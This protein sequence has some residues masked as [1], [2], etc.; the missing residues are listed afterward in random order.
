M[1]GRGYGGSAA[2]ED[3]VMRNLLIAA[4]VALVAYQSYCLVKIENERQALLTGMCKGPYL[5]DL[6][7]L[8]SVQTRT[9]WAWHLVVALADP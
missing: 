1:I 6:E 4:L 7:C 9:H 3:E 8:K 2:R 5:P